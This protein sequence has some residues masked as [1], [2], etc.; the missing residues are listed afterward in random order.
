MH[1]LLIKDLARAEQL[2]RA[3]MA[4]VRGGMDV[5]TP[6][7]GWPSLVFSPVS[8]TSLNATQNMVQYQL[9]R[10]S[11]ADGSAFLAD[12]HVTNTNSQFGQNNIIVGPR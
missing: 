4:A 8:D 11:V 6:S 9:S 10:N 12:V 5:D 3:E 7:Y 1:T 2:D